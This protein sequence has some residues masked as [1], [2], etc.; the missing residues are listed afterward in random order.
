MNPFFTSNPEFEDD[1]LLSRPS[2]WFKEKTSLEQI[3]ARFSKAKNKIRIAS[4][5]FTVKGWDLIRDYIKARQVYLLVGINEPNEKQARAALVKEIRDD[6]AIGHH[7]RRRESVEDL[8]TRM[9]KGQV[10]IVDARASSH[11]AKLYIVDHHTAIN[12]S[13]NATGNGF[14]YQIESG[15]V[16]APSEIKRFIL[17]NSNLS[18]VNTPETLAALNKFNENKVAN[19]IKSF[20]EYFATATDITQE[21][22]TELEEWLQFASPW[23]V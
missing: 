19:W 6:L 9:K 22:L 1:D 13:A 21:L 23:D 11:H 20:D 18:G 4:G 5:F 8:V 2:T 10:S 17:E 15:D 12:T 16:H 7:K 3:R 14:L